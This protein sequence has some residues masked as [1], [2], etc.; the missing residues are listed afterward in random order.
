MLRHA[1][2]LGY[3]GAALTT[4]RDDLT[5]LEP[6][7]RT[8]G[9]DLVSRI[10]LTPR[11]QQELLRSLKRVRRG[12][13]VVSVTCMTKG[14]AVQAA[15]DHRVDILNYSTEPATRGKVWFDRHQAKLAKGALCCYEINI[16][17][18][19]REQRRRAQ[20]LR[21][22]KK[23]AGNALRYGVPVILSSGASSIFHMR[24]P[25][26][27][28][29]LLDILDIGEEAAF[30]MISTNPWRLVERNRRKLEPGF[31]APGVRRVS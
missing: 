21:H 27:L 28:A 25:R 15:K 24:E 22:L 23:E 29:A 31:V 18:M 14:V 1:A 16:N 13:E 30:E 2:S 6:L 12:Y 9:I 11:S 19:L 10:D 5:E 26:A 3:K 20:A 4:T 7:A 17:E 8:L